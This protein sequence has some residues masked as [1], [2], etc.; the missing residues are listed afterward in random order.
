MT[1][2]TTDTRVAIIEAAL[3]CF[4]TQGLRKTTI[5]DIT[6]VAAVSRSTIYEYFADKSAIVAATA[7]YAS[8]LFYR[9]IARGMDRGRTLEDKLGNAAVVVTRGRQFLE[10]E[11]YFD[12]DA[13]S[14]LLTKNAAK[15]L[16]ECG[17][18]LAPYLAAAKV[19][20]EVRKDLDV[21]TAA[22]WFARMLFSLFTTPSARLDMNDPNVVRAFVRR[23]RGPRVLR[24]GVEPAQ[25]QRPNGRVNGDR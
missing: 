1:E 9:E 18:F 21:E 4:R 15:L 5:V 13:V 3:E 25:A 14:L 17:D 2:T 7:E 16:R 6:R 23:A 10:P 8:Q 19:T 11:R 20:G 12:A 24:S 22:E